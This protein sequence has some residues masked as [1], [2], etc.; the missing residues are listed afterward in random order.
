MARRFW[1]LWLD[2]AGA[3]PATGLRRLFH[4]AAAALAVGAVAGM[5]VR[6]IFFDYAMVWRSTFIRDPESAALA[7]RAAFGP[8][9]LALGWPLPG[10]TT[11]RA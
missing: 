2:A 10:A 6:G 3:L 5:F 1:S 4:A 9:A 7:L 11:R 8:A